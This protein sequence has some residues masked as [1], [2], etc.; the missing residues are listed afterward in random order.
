MRRIILYALVVLLI[1]LVNALTFDEFVSTYDLTYNAGTADITSITLDGCTVC[2]NLTITLSL[3]LEPGN[4]AISGFLDNKTATTSGYFFDETGSAELIFYPPF[5]SNN[6]SLWIKMEKEGEFIFFE[7]VTTIDLSN[8]TFNNSSVIEEENNSIV[9][10]T[11]LNDTIINSSL[12]VEYNKSDNL[13]LTF[14]LFDEFSEYIASSESNQS[15]VVFNGT[16]INE[17][18]LNGPY[19]VKASIGGEIYAYTTHYY[20]YSDFQKTPETVSVVTKVFESA[21]QKISR[22]TS[23]VSNFIG[24]KDNETIAVNV[25]A[26][27][28]EQVN[29]SDDEKSNINKTEEYEQEESNFLKKILPQRNFLTGNAVYEGEEEDNNLVLSA[30]I[31]CAVAISLFFVIRRLRN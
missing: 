11:F 25:S 13:S 23:G 22:F 29:M 24:E 19:I 31:I 20:N 17:S 26:Y 28:E 5:D 1:P 4:Y 18:G 12:V 27:H 10:I 3:S 21:K 2:N 15:F 16:A 7:N 8:K 14:H 9:D 6:S 30:L